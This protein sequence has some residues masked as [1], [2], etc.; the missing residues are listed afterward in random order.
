M[1]QQADECP[2]QT[3]PWSYFMQKWANEC[4]AKP[5][6]WSYSITGQFR[7]DKYHEEQISFSELILEDGFLAQYGVNKFQINRF[8][9][10][11]FN[12]GANL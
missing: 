6:L 8:K 7:D 1:H 3:K 9:S 4:S 10:D 12:N 11:I 5:S 2:N